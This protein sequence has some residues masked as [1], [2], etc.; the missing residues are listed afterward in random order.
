MSKNRLNYITLKKL[1]FLFF[2]SFSAAYTSAQLTDYNKIV[3]DAETRPKT[4]EDYLVQLAWKNS[5]QSKILDNTKQMA[6]LEVDLTKR[7]WMDNMQAQWNLNEISLSNIIYDH[8]DPL[9]VAM[10]I[11]NVSATV[12]LDDIF[13]RKKKIE[14]NK[15]EVNIA[16]ENINLLK[17][18]VRA[19]VL[20][21]YY[22]YQS[23]I[24]IL[25]VRT[26]AEQDA[27]ENYILLGQLFKKDKVKFEELNNASIAYINTKESKIKAEVE[28]KKTKAILE[29]IIGVTWEEAEKFGKIYKKD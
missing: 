13:N 29:Q 21:R 16:E 4:F 6:E 14:L 10:P 1:I 26:E 18:R 23:A 3:P 19:E 7:E 20:K 28:I 17:L 5:P 8:D 27:N 9:F 2:L 11:W 24:E 25:K 22:D 15:H 12:N